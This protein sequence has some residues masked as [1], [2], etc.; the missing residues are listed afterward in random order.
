MKGQYFINKLKYRWKRFFFSRPFLYAFT[1]FLFLFPYHGYSQL[2]STY[3]ETIIT[4]SE[5]NIG[6]T[7]MP[8]II[9]YQHAYLPVKE[10][11]DFLS[12]YNAASA[13]DNISGFYIYPGNLYLFDT[14]RNEIVFKDTT[15]N[16]NQNDLL[17]SYNR[18]FLRSDYFEKIFGLKCTFNFRSLS[19]G[20]TT[21]AE[22]PA[23][24]EKRQELMRQNIASLNSGRKADT[25]IK[26]SFSMFRFGAADWQLTTI[27][28]TNGQ[29]NV[30]ANLD[31]G[32]IIAGG[33]ASMY[34]NYN[35]GLPFSSKSQFYKWRFI[36]NDNKIIR[37]INIGR[38]FTN[39][40]SSLIAPLN[41]FKISNTPTTYKRSFGTFTVSNTT[42]PN[43][44]VELYV[45]D[46]LVNYT[47]ADA[48]GF[49]TFEVPMVYG[50]SRIKYKFYGP[51]GEERSSEQNI[52]IPFTF[53]P[54]NQLEYS[55]TG[56]IISDEEKSK[57]SRANLNYGLNNR[58]TIGTGVEYL[59]TVNSGHAMPFINASLRL[60]SS[61][62]LSGEHTYGVVTKANVNYRLA[63]RIQ[64]DFTYAKYA[65]G[66]TA[67]RLSYLEEKRVMVSMP[68]R[69]KFFNGFSRLT[70]DKVTLPQNKLTFVK[71]KYT[72][73]EF[74]LGGVVAGISSNLT[75]YARFTDITPKIY[76]K[77]SV[78]FQLPK[79]I[80]FTPQAQ[81]EYQEK[82]FSILRSE[83]EKRIFKT[84]FL[85]FSYERNLFK[86]TNIFM[87]GIRLNLSFAQA[88]FTIR[89]YDHST[90]FIQTS[91]GGLMFNSHTGYLMASNQTNVGRGGL[92]ISP[93]LD[94][95]CNGIRDEG[96]P[97][98]QGL[99]VRI[100]L[101][102][103]QQNKN[104]TLIKITGL[105]AYNKYYIDL[106]KNSFEN[107][108]WKIRNKVIEV[109]ADPNNFKLIEVPVAVL[110]EVSGMV[111]KNN[112]KEGMGGV[113]VNI[114][115]QNGNLVAKTL[116]EPDGYFSYLGLAPGA[117]KVLI[118][119][120]QLLKI[121][122]IN[123]TGSV[124]FNITSKKEGDIVDG[125]ELILSE[126]HKNETKD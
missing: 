13:S 72:N 5:P 28:E 61:V 22:L 112:L 113:I 17:V 16:L 73:A 90:Q 99:I 116:S 68:I 20:I 47:K 25:V 66:Q 82:G 36:N 4:V 97:G 74:M 11:F 30:R 76:S 123:T 108:A 63:N 8:A 23:V 53:L 98:V 49:F 114:Y 14:K 75:T 9:H 84:G 21:K 65:P 109:I 89:K 96:E 31:L 64:L 45:N 104:D 59:S 92:L 26:N 40:T 106:D 56:G 1:C 105:E 119:E 15:I 67:V 3:D 101:G 48:A 70:I 35:S 62:I 19:V 18:L 124:P 54:A 77:L 86:K 117:Y 24:R 69:T 100:P 121:N 33:E 34:L 38:V 115:D 80:R 102:Q 10:L 39:S 37:Q 78:T 41:G 93:F 58:L 27:N 118:D 42:E 6:R 120:S 91:S 50:S 44:I 107:P 52:S 85:N 81:Y 57:F 43:W 51:Y 103:I 126:I 46:I 60:G 55:I 95:N 12:I 88:A 32:G 71:T 29:N 7:D 79:G 94:Y 83:F 110:G 125:V 122:M 2:D 87:T 111:Y